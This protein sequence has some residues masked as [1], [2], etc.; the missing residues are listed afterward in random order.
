M[1]IENPIDAL[2]IAIIIK[3]YIKAIVLITHIDYSRGKVL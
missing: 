1:V 2:A 3:N